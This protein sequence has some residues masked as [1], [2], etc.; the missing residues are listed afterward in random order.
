[1]SAVGFLLSVDGTGPSVLIVL[2]ADMGVPTCTLEGAVP[3]TPLRREP[4][5]PWQQHTS[6]VDTESRNQDALGV[7]SSNLLVFPESSHRAVTA[8]LNVGDPSSIQY[9]ISL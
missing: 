5:A 1:M 8:H 9:P 6:T 7:V 3:A 2:L 4:S